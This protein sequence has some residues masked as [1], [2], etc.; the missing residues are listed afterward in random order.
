MIGKERAA[1]KRDSVAGRS[2]GR[3]AADEHKSNGRDNCKLHE[4]HFGT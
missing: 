2:A 1:M 3:T 4:R